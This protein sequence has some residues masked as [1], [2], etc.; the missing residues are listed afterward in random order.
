MYK[1]IKPCVQDLDVQTD[2]TICDLFQ[3]DMISSN[4]KMN[5]PI[6]TFMIDES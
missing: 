2:K 5:E 6:G 1:L 3:S 4:V